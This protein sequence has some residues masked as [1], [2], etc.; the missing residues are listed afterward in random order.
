MATPDGKSRKEKKKNMT[1]WLK[2][3]YKELLITSSPLPQDFC[4]EVMVKTKI[5]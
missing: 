5:R 2:P 4:Y 3:F 1:P